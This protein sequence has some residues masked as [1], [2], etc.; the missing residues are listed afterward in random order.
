[1]STIKSA[2]K[3]ASET[4]KANSLAMTKLVER[5]KS[6]LTEIET[7]GSESSRAREKSRGKL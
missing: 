5:L 2:L 7:G 3:P 1:M 6:T 4:F